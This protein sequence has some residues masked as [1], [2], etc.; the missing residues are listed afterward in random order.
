MSAAW[1][2]GSRVAGPAVRGPACPVRTS[3]SKEAASRVALFCQF[4]DFARLEIQ[5]CLLF[6]ALD[7]SQRGRRSNLPAP[8]I[9]PELLPDPASRLQPRGAS[10]VRP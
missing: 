7:D 6:G 10:P 1:S 3:R 9:I 5:D 8:R 2:C 4:A